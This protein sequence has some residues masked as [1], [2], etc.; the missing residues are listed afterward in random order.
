MNTNMNM[1]IINCIIISCLVIIVILLVWHI[2]KNPIQEYMTDEAK[3]STTIEITPEPIKI[4]TNMEKIMPEIITQKTNPPDISSET[5]ISSEQKSSTILPSDIPSQ[6]NKTVNYPEQSDKLS[7]GTTLL[8]EELK[9]IQEETKKLQEETKKLQEQKNRDSASTDNSSKSI[10]GKIQNDSVDDEDIVKNKVLCDNDVMTI[11][12]R[13]VTVETPR[14]KNS[15]KMD[16]TRC[17]KEKKYYASYDDLAGK[18]MNDGYCD[19]YDND[20]YNYNKQHVGEYLHDFRFDDKE[21][22]CATRKII[23]PDKHNMDQFANF[24]DKVHQS[25]HQNNLSMRVANMRLNEK[26]ENKGRNIRD[27]H[28]N[29]THEVRGYN[30][31]FMRPQ[32]DKYSSEYGHGPCKESIYNKHCVKLPKQDNISNSHYYTQKIDDNNILS[33]DNWAYNVDKS[34]SGGEIGENLFGY[35]PMGMDMQVVKSR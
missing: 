16:N 8:R 15:N 20:N 21:K 2:C 3:P 29:L 6:S 18:T 1:K 11:Y 32:D 12:E 24:R 13:F 17:A 19:N 7:E 9:K 4:T 35:D 14:N 5:L 23:D 34:M 30:K 25:S 33:P 27:I 28:D 10:D 26:D 31:K 22:Y